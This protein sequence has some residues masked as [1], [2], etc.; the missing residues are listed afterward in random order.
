MAIAVVP[1]LIMSVFTVYA[2]EER[3]L[4]EVLLE[5]GLMRAEITDLEAK[6]ASREATNLAAQNQEPPPGQVEVT[7]LSTI[8][9]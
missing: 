3:T 1:L 5:N 7:P 9:C 4:K 2:Q 6:L 8:S